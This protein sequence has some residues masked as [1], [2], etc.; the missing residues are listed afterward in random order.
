MSYSS[1]DDR[2]LARANGHRLS[3][4]KI[5]RAE[6]DALDQPVP[7]QAAKMAG[8]SVRNGPLEDAMD[9]DEPAT[10]GASKRKSRTSISKVNYKD[11][12]SSDDAAPL[13]KRQKK[14]ANR[15][16]ESDSD[17]EPIARARGKKLPPSYDETAL[18]ESSGD[19]D[20]PLSVKLA[21]KKR[22][23][24]KEAEKQAKVIRAKERTKKPATKKAVKDES[25][26]DVPL[27][28]SSAS[29]RRSNGTAAKRKSN[30]VKKEESD[31]DAPIS[32]KAKAKPTS[33]A[34]KA[35]KAESKKASESED[36]EEYAWWN[37]PK[38]E[39]DDIKWTTLEHNGVLFPT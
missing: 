4:S 30:G 39:N 12:E 20:E 17:D 1:D 19:D 31:S 37:A 27:A 38:K 35:V 33:S 34:K 26:D 16:P 7:K 32:K 3:S 36:E 22:D 21:Q 10:N 11:D 24:E 13:A 2:P 25:D 15:V 29:K 23:M 14:Q 28:K 6:D 8:L 9:I 18:P 5:S